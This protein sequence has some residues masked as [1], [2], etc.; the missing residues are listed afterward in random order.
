[1]ICVPRFYPGAGPAGGGGAAP[2]VTVATFADLPTTRPDGYLV[3]VTAQSGLTEVIVRWDN[4]GGVWLLEQATCAYSVHSAVQ[5]AGAGEWYD[6]GGIT[7]ETADGAY[8][9]DTTYDV[10]WRWASTP[11]QFV[12]PDVY[13]GTIVIRTPLVGD[14]ATPT[15]WTTATIDAGGTAS[16]TTDGT[17]LTLSA[18][19]SG[20]GVTVAYVL[21]AD[22]GLLTA[23]NAYMR[24]LVQIT[25]LTTGT[26]T[27]QAI[28]RASVEDGTDG[29]DFGSMT[30]VG[31]GGAN[32]TGGWF[33]AAIGF[34]YAAQSAITQNL[35]SAETLLE[36]RKI[37]T[38]IEARAGGAASTWQAIAGATVRSSVSTQFVF[39]ATAIRSGGTST[40]IATIREVCPMR[41]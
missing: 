13:A 31:G 18:V 27:A 4:S 24:A 34:D 9:Q 20:A 14:S 16:I 41:F 29:F 6:T 17:K 28:F 39:V 3:A 40:V 30:N 37:G 2:D 25:T 5:F 10:V 23:T 35:T 38:N 1:M 8:V 36:I 22:A 21:I 19:T 33:D 11:A 12:P 7:V 15:D 26:G 32:R